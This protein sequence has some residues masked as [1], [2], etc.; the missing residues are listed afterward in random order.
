MITFSHPCIWEVHN[1][2][3]LFLI[4]FVTVS[5][6]YN[7]SVTGSLADGGLIKKGRSDSGYPGT[8]GNSSEDQ[9]HQKVPLHNLDPSSLPSEEEQP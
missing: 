6:F 2:S 9:K 5:I 4:F 1:R 7:R 8:T 3:I